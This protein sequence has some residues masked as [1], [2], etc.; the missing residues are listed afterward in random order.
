MVGAGAALDAAS[1]GLRVALIERDDIASGTSSRS[2]RLIHGGLRYLEQM[3]VGLV[4]EALA[5]RSRLL[6]NA[7]HLV[8]LE[9]LLFPL[10]GTILSRPF[11]GTGLTLYDLLGAAR[12]GGRHRFL[13][14]AASLEHTPSLRRKGLR[15]SF[16]FHDGVEDDARFAL[17]VARTAQTLGAVVATRVSAHGALH[18]G[19][20]DRRSACPRRAQRRWSSTSG[21][22]R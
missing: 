3:R 11:Y 16:V 18:A 10:F 1:R 19:S 14:V 22:R 13:D 17:A 12:D 4:R 6:Q 15:G 7:P 21:P 2:S 8:H 9:P 5:E 20:S